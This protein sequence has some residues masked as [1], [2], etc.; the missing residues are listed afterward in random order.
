MVMIHFRRNASL[1]WYEVV[2][3]QHSHELPPPSFD[4]MMELGSL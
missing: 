2:L 3:A 4:C 1:S